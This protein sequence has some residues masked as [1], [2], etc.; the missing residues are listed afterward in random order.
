ML[1]LNI[2]D[3]VFF[4]RLSEFIMADRTAQIEARVTKV[5]IEWTYAHWEEPIKYIFNIGEANLNGTI[6]E[7]FETE[8][9]ARVFAQ[10][11]ISKISIVID[12]QEPEVEEDEKEVNEGPVANK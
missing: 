3:S 11:K 4:V 8:E 10:D 2:G 6:D 12:L 9:E 7:F 1:N 5:T